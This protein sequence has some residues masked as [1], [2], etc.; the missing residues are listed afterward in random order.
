[1]SLEL[2]RLGGDGSKVKGDVG[3]GEVSEVRGGGLEGLEEGL[4]RGV[5]LKLGG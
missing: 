5:N 3:L 1:M 2:V 4:A